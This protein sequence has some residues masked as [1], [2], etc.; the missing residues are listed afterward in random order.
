MSQRKNTKRK[1]V[2]SL[3][4][5]YDSSGFRTIKEGERLGKDAAHVSYGSVGQ[6]ILDFSFD[7][8]VFQYSFHEPEWQTL[9]IGEDAFRDFIRKNYIESIPKGMPGVDDF[10]HYKVVWS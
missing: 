9:R 5:T 6:P 4:G 3:A 10:S 2:T 1:G 8:R 7:I